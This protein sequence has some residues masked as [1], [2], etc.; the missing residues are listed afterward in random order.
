MSSNRGRNPPM[1]GCS[2]S[3][4]IGM[5]SGRAWTAGDLEPVDDERTRL[6]GDVVDG[7][8]AQC[9]HAPEA[10]ESSRQP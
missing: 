6:D 5:P 7:S 8:F 2:T 10:I 1:S 4:A 9:C 3:P